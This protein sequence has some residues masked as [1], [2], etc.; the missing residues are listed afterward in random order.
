LG[1]KA[2]GAMAT[3]KQQLLAG[4]SVEV[5]GYALSPAL[6][7]SL[8]QAALEPPRNSAQAIWLELSAQPA[9]AVSPVISTLAQQWAA[10]GTVVDAQ[11]IQ[12]PLFW[13]T[14]EIEDAPALLL[15]TLNCLRAAR[16]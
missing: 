2:A 4:E 5:A 11:Q 10:A 1:G 16:A 12:G 13:Q 6:A 7:N 8:E 15:A 14:S 9:A 3:L